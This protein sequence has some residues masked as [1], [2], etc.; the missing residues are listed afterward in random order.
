MLF[1][2]PSHI[3]VER[4]LV[5]IEGQLRR[6]PS[7]SLPTPWRDADYSQGRSTRRHGNSAGG[8]VVVIQLEEAIQV[9]YD[10]VD[11]PKLQC[12]TT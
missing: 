1:D 9:I 12:I 7:V 11:V 6:L 4:L 5:V 2:S 8:G 10:L 3:H